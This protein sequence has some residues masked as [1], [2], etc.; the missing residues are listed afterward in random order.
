MTGKIKTI[1]SEKGYGFIRSGTKE[2]FFHY[3]DFEG[4]FHDLEEMFNLK[5]DINVEFELG[6]SP[7]GPRAANV[8]IV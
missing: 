1:K 6:E 5:K 7:K 2:Y 3:S 4:S 8:R